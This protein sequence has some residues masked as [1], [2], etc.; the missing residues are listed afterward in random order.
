MQI[1]QDFIMEEDTRQM[2]MVENLP[3]H[4]AIIM[5]GNGRWAKE[6]GLVR[7]DGHKAGAHAVQKVVTECRK[8][9][10]KYLTLYTFSHENWQRPQEEVSTLFSL[11]VEFL[12]Q[13][14]PRMVR[15]SVALNVLGD[16]DELPLVTRTALAHAIKRTA[17]T[18]DNPTKL[19]LNLALNYGSRRE[20]LRAVRGIVQAKVPAEEITEEI[21]RD[22]LYTKDMP[23]PDLVIRTSGEIRI[24]NYLLFQC[25]YSEFYFSKTFWP[26][27]DEEELKRALES[28]ALR[29]RR[30]GKTQEQLS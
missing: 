11:L 28:Y 18:E 5:D 6:R 17:G 21:F 10:I 20:I 23:D 12:K 1:L 25:A 15:E 3:Q 22:H 13:E 27:F 24:S 8:L 26:D 2:N 4:I 29:Q 30:F 19:Y 16:M 14:V 9:G 7:T